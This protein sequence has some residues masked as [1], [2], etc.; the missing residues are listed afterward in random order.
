V[1]V[2]AEMVPGEKLKSAEVIEPGKAAEAF[3]T[4][5]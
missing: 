3:F 1:P 4:F 5:E 2:S